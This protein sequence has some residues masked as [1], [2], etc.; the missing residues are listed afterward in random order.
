MVLLVTIGLTVVYRVCATG[1]FSVV[2]ATFFLFKYYIHNHPHT[3]VPVFDAYI[4]L[5][6]TQGHYR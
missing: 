5:K 2:A 3:K 1:L 6:Y 4:M